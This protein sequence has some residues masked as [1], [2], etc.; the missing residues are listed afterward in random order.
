MAATPNRVASTRS[1]AVGVPPRW[2]WPR[3]VTRVSKPVRCS[4][5]SASMLPIPPR[6]A[7]PNCVH[8]AAMRAL[9]VPSSGVAPSAT[10]TI[11]A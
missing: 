11:D 10:T 7:W 4:I 1:N 5:S 3:I 6:R 2:T 9:S 8:L